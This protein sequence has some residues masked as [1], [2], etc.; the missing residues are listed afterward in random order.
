VA[1]LKALYAVAFDVGTHD[2]LMSGV[3]ALDQAL[4]AYAITHTYETYEGDQYIESK[5]DLR[6]VHCFFLRKTQSS[7]SK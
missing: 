6:R 5:C 7:S 4:T 2:S 3:Q 1:G